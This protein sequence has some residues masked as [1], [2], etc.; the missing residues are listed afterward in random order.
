MTS[1]NLFLKAGY[2]C[3]VFFIMASMFLPK[4]V[5]AEEND[6]IDEDGLY[7]RTDGYYKMV[8]EEDNVLMKTGRILN[9]GNKFLNQDNELY[10]VVHVEDDVARAEFVEEVDLESREAKVRADENFEAKK[11]VQDNERT[12]GLYHSHGAE[13]Y[14]PSD[15][16]ESIDEGGGII[17][18]GMTL[19]DSL[20]EKN[21]NAI[22]SDETHVPHDAGAYSRSR[23]TVE[24]LMQN[25]PDALIDIH[26]DAAPKE[27][28]KVDLGFD[29]VVQTL[30]V[31]GQQQPNFE[32][33]KAF[34][35]GLKAIGDEMYDGFIKGILYADG[36]YNQ[37]L[38]PRNILVEIGGHEN[39]RESAQASA[40]LFAGVLNETLYG[41]EEGTGAGPA[42]QIAGEGGV[43]GR[44][45]RSVVWIIG[46]L[47]VAIGIF[48][49]INYKNL[50]QVK[51]RL[52]HFFTKEF[53][54][55][56]GPQKSNRDKNQGE[57]G[58]KE[59]K[60]K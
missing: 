10:K 47:I 56:L 60:D 24:E 36:S 21:V 32:E 26:R 7:E 16:E 58:N 9:T 17:Q 37:D 57:D 30:L 34:A 33:N 18:V 27:E 8:D 3:L 13:S 31:V 54:N 51:E 49:A 5:L 44:V 23:R 19:K 42:D 12:I 40:S 6:E 55:F 15:G 59:D 4:D 14:E 22:W 25:N 28:Y 2:I 29:E 50:D 39:T 52:K 20:K 53:S 48:L 43:A 45:A 46:L 41:G 35:E 11:A 1:K 38:H